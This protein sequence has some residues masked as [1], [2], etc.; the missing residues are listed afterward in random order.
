MSAFSNV[1]ISAPVEHAKQ[2]QENLAQGLESLED[3]QVP[4]IEHPTIITQDINKGKERT[5]GLNICFDI[6]TAKPS[7]NVIKNKD[8]NHLTKLDQ[9]IT[10]GAPE[11]G[12]GSVVTWS[13]RMTDIVDNRKYVSVVCRRSLDKFRFRPQ[14]INETPVVN[15]GGRNGH[16]IYPLGGDDIEVGD[17]TTGPGTQTQRNNSN[18]AKEANLES[19]AVMNYFPEEEENT[20]VGGDSNF[21]KYELDNGRCS[22]TVLDTRQE[23]VIGRGIGSDIRQY[24]AGTSQEKISDSMMN[25]E[26]VEI[27]CDDYGDIDDDEMMMA[28]YGFEGYAA[29]E[30][31][32]TVSS[33]Y[34][35]DELPSVESTGQYHL[36]QGQEL[37]PS[38]HLAPQELILCEQL[39]QP[40]QGHQ[41]FSSTP[42]MGTQMLNFCPSSGTLIDAKLRDSLPTTMEN[43]SPPS[44]VG[45][46]LNNYSQEQEIFDCN[47]QGSL[48][49]ED[50]TGIEGNSAKVRRTALTGAH[51]IEMGFDLLKSPHKIQ[52]WLPDPKETPCISEEGAGEEGEEER[53]GK[54]KNLMVEL[55]KKRPKVAAKKRAAGMVCDKEPLKRRKI[56]ICN[57]SQFK[58]SDYT[59]A[60]SFLPYSAVSFNERYDRDGKMKPF[61]RPQF[62]PVVS[63]KPTVAGLGAR[64]S[65]KTCFR[66]GEALKIGWM[67]A[68]GHLTGDALVELY[69]IY[70]SLFWQRIC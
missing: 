14:M 31:D 56:R 62:P 60:S 46:A 51:Q 42:N 65:V 52:E 37:L 12:P 13:Q 27:D 24:K 59:I 35:A 58:I 39:V 28:V 4:N 22:S 67:L 20:R 57:P 18:F 1:N 11:S 41:Q 63:E 43:F 61:V 21:N 17:P 7:A 53:E 47:L 15:T 45:F 68:S 50:S 54:K 49:Q 16:S 70:D 33:V 48:P 25:S 10:A 32:I 30:E 40:I 26:L 3:E 19:F 44:S 55:K 23:L 5:N 29:W 69:G 64:L 38:P 9:D 2:N 66:V 36:N 8:M 6:R 34:S